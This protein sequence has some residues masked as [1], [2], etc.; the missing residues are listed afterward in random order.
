MSGAK[1]GFAILSLL[2]GEEYCITGLISLDQLQK[3]TL[4]SKL[5][6]PR[7]TTEDRSR[8]RFR[9]LHKVM[10]PGRTGLSEGGSA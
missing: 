10:G 1:K 5:P 2:K 8:Y 6:F 4:D 9:V 3:S 7:V